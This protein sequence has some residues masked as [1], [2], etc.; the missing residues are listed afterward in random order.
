[1]TTVV[2]LLGAPGAGKGTQATRLSKGLGLPHISTGDLFRSNLS[3]GTPLGERARGFM[4]SGELVPDELVLEMLFDRVQAADC[5][6][7]Y[8]LDG[9]PRTIAQADALEARLD[10]LASVQRVIIDIRVPDEVIENRI[11]QRRTCSSCGH[12]CH[13]EHSPPS[14]EGRCDACGS[15]LQQRKDDTA[16]VVRTR[17]EEYHS[18]TAPLVEYYG[19]RGAVCAVDGV[20]DPEEVFAACKACIQTSQPSSMTG[21]SPSAASEGAR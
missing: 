5:G 18:K 17:L 12:I 20:Q 19:S 10:G 7:G 2:I 9:F 15:E 11:V 3:G 14:V 8:L 13:L 16:E 6:Q 4:E 1:M 21:G